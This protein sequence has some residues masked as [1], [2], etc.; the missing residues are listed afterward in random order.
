MNAQHAASAPPL[1]PASQHTPLATA[2]MMGSARRCRGRTTTEQYAT[3][4]TSASRTGYLR[5]KTGGPGA[6]SGSAHGPK[7]GEVGFCVSNLS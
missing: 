2:V 3:T 1:S 5:R 6:G 7:G 4:H